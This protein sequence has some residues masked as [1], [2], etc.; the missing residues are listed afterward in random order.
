MS[1][2]GIAAAVLGIAG[3]APCI[4][5]T[6]HGKIKPHRVTWLILL[7]LSVISFASQFA[8][9]ARA[10]LFLFGWLVV[11]NLIMVG[12]A[13]RRNG[14]YGVTPANVVCFALA[15]AGV[16][17]WQITES[18]LAALVCVLF[19]DGINGW[20]IVVKSLRHPHTETLGLRSLG[21]VACTLNVLAV[22]AFDVI[23]LAATVQLLILNVLIVAAILLGRSTAPDALI[24]Q[25]RRGSPR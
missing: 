25:R 3:S 22:D 24:Q 9:G 14:R 1:H 18:A 12:L 2:W 6:I 13:F 11:N 19:A 10:S 16:W 15:V 7:A 8:L 17:S 23:L 5:N 4:Y 20:L 21:V